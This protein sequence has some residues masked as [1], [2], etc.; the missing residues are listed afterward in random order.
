[1]SVKKF[2]ENSEDPWK[3]PVSAMGLRY[4]VRTLGSGRC[5]LPWPCGPQ[6][7]GVSLGMSTTKWLFACGKLAVAGMVCRSLVSDQTPVRM[8]GLVLPKIMTILR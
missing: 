5:S 1:M 3:M 4:R 2:R 8:P 6:L 7:C